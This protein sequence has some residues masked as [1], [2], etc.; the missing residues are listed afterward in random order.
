MVRR[1]RAAVIG[2]ALAG[3][4]ALATAAGAA[5]STSVKERSGPLTATL[6]AGTHTPKVGVKW[7]L[8]VTATLN[9]KPAHATAYYQFLFG[10]T[11]VS[12]TYVLGNKHFSFSGHYSDTLVFPPASSGEPLTLSVVIKAAGHTVKLPWSIKSHT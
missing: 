8:T 3:S 5:S 7:P 12:T 2:L 10:G 1:T 9:G 6:Q 4:F 11:V